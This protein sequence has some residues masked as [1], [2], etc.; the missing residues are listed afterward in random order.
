MTDA[1]NEAAL[2]HL[3]TIARETGINARSVASTA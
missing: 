3:D 2:K 1:P